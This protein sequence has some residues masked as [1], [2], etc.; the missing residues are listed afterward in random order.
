MKTTIEIPENELKDLIEY[1]KA[2]TKKEAILTAVR[3]YNNRKRMAKLSRILGTFE[4]F[5]NQEELNKMRLEQ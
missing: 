4:D 1:S 2:K 3:D 5:M